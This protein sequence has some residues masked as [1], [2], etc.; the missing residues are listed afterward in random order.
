[1]KQLSPIQLNII[2]AL[3]DG[4]CHSGNELGKTLGISRTAV[5]KHMKQLIDLG[6]PVISLAQ[7]GYQLEKPFFLLDEHRIKEALHHKK[8][9]QPFNLHLFT[10]LPSTN[11]YLKELP[12][13][14]TLEICC[15]EQQTQGRGRFGRVWH[16]PFGENIYLSLKWNLQCELNKLSGLSLVTS[17]AIANALKE[18]IPNEEIKIKWPNDILWGD[19]KLC[20]ILIEILAESNANA[21]V[22][23]GI[24][25]NV[26]SDTRNN[27]LPDKV[28]C[29][30]FEMLGNSLDRNV[31]ISCV[32][33]KLMLYI[34]RLLEH[35]LLVFINEWN[36]YDYLVGKQI[37]VTQAT[38]QFNGVA[39]GIDET[40][41]LIIEELDGQRHFLSSGDTTLNQGD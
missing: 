38:M 40:G 27:P 19:K 16:S 39:C 25:L 20:G 1:M 11:Q 15:A 34:K 10:T 23:I 17:L 21:Q 12:Q 2:D 35:G 24:G 36:D 22:I 31:L 4:A 28:W 41:L 30:L 6:V 3:S 32:L 9:P 26:N 33:E 29:S 37:T 7:T 18:F 13:S 8:F 14:Q 5:W